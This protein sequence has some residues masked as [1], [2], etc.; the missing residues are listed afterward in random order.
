MYV[1]GSACKKQCFFKKTVDCVNLETG[2]SRRM[3]SDLYQQRLALLREALKK[4]RIDG[5]LL[6]VNDPFQGEYVPEYWQRLPWLTGFT[7]SAGSVLVLMDRA[8]FFTDGRYTL[9]AQKEL[10]GTLYDITDIADI[11]PAKW[12]SQHVDNI[13]I[14]YD[15]ML[16]TVSQL[17]SFKKYLQDC[18]VSLKAVIN[19]VDELWSERP[20]PPHGKIVEHLI[21]FAGKSSEEKIKAITQ[22][23]Q[24]ANA[25]TLLLTAPD[26]I[27][28]LLNIRG[29]DVPYTPLALC[30]AMVDRSG[31]VTIYTDEARCDEALKQYINIKPENLLISDLKQLNSSVIIDPTSCPVVFYELL[32]SAGVDIIQQDD[33]CVLPKAY[34]NLVEQEGVYNAHIRDGVALTKLLYWIEKESQSGQLTELDVIAKAEAFRS[35]QQHFVYPSFNTIAGAGAHGAIIHYRADEYSNAVLENNALFLLDSGGQYLDGTTDVTRTIAIG[36]PTQ[37]QQDRFTRVLKGHIAIATAKFPKGTTGSQLDPFARQYLWEI[38]EDYAHGTG[39]GV[40]SYLQVHE[41]PQRISKRGGDVALENGMILSNEPGFYKEGEYGIRIENLVMAI[42]Q[43]GIIEFETITLAPINKNLIIKDYLSKKEKSWLND[44][45]AK[46]LDK[47]APKLDAEEQAWL[48]QACA[49]I[50]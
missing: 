42:D 8:L 14:G 13:V 2:Y 37:E 48:E 32:L 21:E 22:E 50:A 9:Q 28:W 34:K 35:E 30:F 45:H 1:K 15:A 25:D 41:G 38:G 43:E 39:H 46:I 36:N 33:P 20:L 7:G 40:G 18:G 47:V 29:S 19:P 26:S 23:I 3:E 11:T 17:A 6:P 44:Y 49:P 27:N 16:H 31:D 4:L 5:F 12:L 10:D 24:K